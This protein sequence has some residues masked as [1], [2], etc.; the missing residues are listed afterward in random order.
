MQDNQDFVCSGRLRMTFTQF[1]RRKCLLG[2]EIMKY[3]V[4]LI[5][6]CI[7]AIKQGHQDRKTTPVKY[8]E[9]FSQ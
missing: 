7:T 2:C 8:F 5:H 3:I 1:I 6:I 9:E 4:G